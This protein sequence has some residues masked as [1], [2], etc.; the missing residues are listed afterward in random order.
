MMTIRRVLVATDFSEASNAAL[1]YGREL[2]G[3]FGATLHVLNVVQ[4]IYVDILGAENYVGIAP[5]FQQ[6][7]EDDA[8]A[9]LKE[10]VVDRDQSGPSITPVV[11]T[12]SAPAFVIVGYARE[13]VID[14]IVMGTHGRGGF[15]H[16]L[17]GSVAEQVV[18]L[19]PCPVLTVRH[20][21]REF[22]RPDTDSALARA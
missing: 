1:T 5:D 20:P 14:L 9:R 18:R 19:A 3:R 22:V 16:L 12:A 21:E 13:Q 15:A 2:A 8:R 6:Q 4:E 10:L 11:V 17:L 7:I